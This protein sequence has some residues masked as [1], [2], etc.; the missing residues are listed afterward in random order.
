MSARERERESEREWC[1]LTILFA[2]EGGKSGLN[3]QALTG[4][5]RKPRPKKP[6]EVRRVELYSAGTS[7][8]VE[9]ER[10][11]VELVTCGWQAGR[12]DCLNWSPC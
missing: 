11:L 8:V 6:V 2:G 5:G 3:L 12:L 7:F 9:L 4:S 10:D 1:R